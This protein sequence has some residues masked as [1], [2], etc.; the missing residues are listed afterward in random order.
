MGSAIF[1]AALLV[2][3]GKMKESARLQREW[4]AKAEEVRLAKAA[5]L[6]GKPL[7]S[8]VQA[9]LQADLAYL[10]EREEAERQLLC[11]QLPCS[12]TPVADAMTESRVRCGNSSCSIVD[13]RTETIVCVGAVVVLTVFLLAISQ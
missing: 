5:A 8:D 7:P 6:G 3:L 1:V 4:A 9:A 11:F 12:S 2:I 13:E 10:L